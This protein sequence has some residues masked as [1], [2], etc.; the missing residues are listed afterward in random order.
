MRC[1][2]CFILL[3]F[4]FLSYG[5]CWIVFFSLE[6]DPPYA[7]PEGFCPE[8][9]QGL[10]HR[11]ECGA[12]SN[13]HDYHAYKSTKD[14]LSTTARDCAWA[15]SVACMDMLTEPCATCWIENMKCTRDHCLFVCLWGLHYAQLHPQCID[16]DEMFCGDAFKKCAGLNRRR[17]NITTDI[18]RDECCRHYRCRAGSA[19]PW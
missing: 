2:C 12:C 3:L 5:V 19:F 15:P 11:G 14:T 9:S 13:N 17:A 6:Y 8:F 1:K 7:C 10:S 4:L 16:C 18:R